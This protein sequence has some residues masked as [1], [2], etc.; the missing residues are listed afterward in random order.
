MDKLIK[1]IAV[2]LDIVEKSLLGAST[3]HGKRIAVLSVA[4]GKHL[5]FD[6]DKL[7]ALS[8]CALLHD[9]ALTEYIL[10]ERLLAERMGTNKDPSMRLHCEIG[11]KNVDTLGLKS[12]DVNGLVLYHHEWADGSGPFGKYGGDYPLGAELIGLADSLDVTHHLQTIST[13]SLL[14][15][16][17]S[18]EQDIGTHYTSRSARALL[19]V[20]DEP[21]LISLRDEH[22]I[23]I[24]DQRINPWVVDMEDQ[25]I[26]NLSQFVARIIDYKSAFTMHH[27]IGIAN[28]AWFMGEHYGY[29]LSHKSELYLAAALH[30]IGKL[31]TP[32]EVLEKPGMLTDEEIVTIKD[33]V[34]QTYKLLKDINGMEKICDWASNH[35]EKLDGSGYPF[36]KKADALDFNSRLLAC[37]D[38]Y[39]A[40]SEERPYH[41]GR[42]HADTM[43]IMY[44]MVSAGSID[45]EV[46]R[47]LDKTLAGYSN[48]DETPKWKLT[49]PVH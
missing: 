36:G 49:S 37:L 1:A 23:Q 42:S 11:Q 9:N 10:S 28:K 16:C 14:K 31:T 44:D 47:D 38:V 33:H 20:F 6:G 32:T 35:H 18:I 17:A 22:I 30:D 26:L 45:P 13:D 29:D 21:M 19:A 43:K 40:V 41:P 7:R 39:Q 15:L 12:E 4:M 25:T 46:T 34:L 24:I 3:H 8:C 27:S 2:A 5:G 48:P